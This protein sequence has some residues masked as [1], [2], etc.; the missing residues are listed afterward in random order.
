MAE[1]TL[2]AVHAWSKGS[3]TIEVNPGSDPLQDAFN[4]R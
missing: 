1:L 2:S 3:Y 4:V